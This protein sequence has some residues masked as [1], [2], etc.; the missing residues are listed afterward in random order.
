LEK[1]YRESKSA[2]QILMDD[3]RQQYLDPLI[4]HLNP[5]TDFRMITAAF[6]KV[7]SVYRYNCV[8]PASNEVISAFM[9]VIIII[10]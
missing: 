7:L 1:N 10:S 9:K 3:L 8:G 4:K 6:E 5:S 2:C